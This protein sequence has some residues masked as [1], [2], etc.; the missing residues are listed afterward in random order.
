M[1]VIK[2]KK[3]GHR[4]N[5]V[6]SKYWDRENKEVMEADECYLRYENGKIVRGCSWDNVDNLT[7]KAIRKMF[8]SGKRK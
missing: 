8:S 7:K 2:C 6:F 3:C 1:S 5:S 4:T